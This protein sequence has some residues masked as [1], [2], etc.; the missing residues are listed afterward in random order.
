[1]YVMIL[2]HTVLTITVVNKNKH[3]DI[4]NRI[5]VTRQAV[6]EGEM[7]NRDQP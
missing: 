4:E 5:V 7:G 6:G 3:V 2:T 1:M